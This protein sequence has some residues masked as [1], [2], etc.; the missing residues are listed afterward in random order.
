MKNFIY[1]FKNVVVLVCTITFFACQGN[2]KEVKKMS[3]ADNEP[4]AEGINVNLKYTDSGRLVTNL[5]APKLID[6]RNFDYPYI[7]FPDG[8][9]LHYWDAENKESI[10]T[11]DYAIQY[12]K[13]NLI[14]L[15]KNVHLITSD[16]TQLTA[17]QMYWDQK[18][19]WIFTNQ[20]YQITFKDGS[21]NEGQMFDSNQ[22][23]TIFLSRKNTGVQ[24]IDKKETDGQ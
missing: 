2:Y 17:E 3:L 19:S 15:R 10:V 14:D 5:I 9:E 22:D 6:F 4:V 21:Y 20:P 11:A 13:S 24:L 1:S 18:E 7:E 23:F 16:S 8:I 12:D